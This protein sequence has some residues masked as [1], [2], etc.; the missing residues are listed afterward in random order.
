M[1][2]MRS[3]HA[4]AP[5]SLSLRPPTRRQLVSDAAHPPRASNIHELRALQKARAERDA[6]AADERAASLSQTLASRTRR[7]RAHA[8]GVCCHGMCL[9]CDEQ[10]PRRC[11]VMAGSVSCSC[12]GTLMCARPS[13]ATCSMLAAAIHACPC[14]PPL[15]PGLCVQAGPRVIWGEGS[16]EYA[17]GS[18]RTTA[19]R[20]SGF[21]KVTQWPYGAPAL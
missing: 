10:A 16:Q 7:V 11:R 3:S 12:C 2:T 14:L 4:H 5:P 21:V 9:W 15:L 6:A 20:T 19:D 17:P 18:P 1:P 8:C 13:P